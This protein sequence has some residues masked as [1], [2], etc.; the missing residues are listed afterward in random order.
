MGNSLFYSTEFF[1]KNNPDGTKM[2]KN[3]KERT[4]MYYFRI[5]LKFRQQFSNISDFQ[6]KKSPAFLRN[7]FY[8][9]EFEVKKQST[10]DVTKV[11]S[12][13]WMKSHL[14]LWKNNI[15]QYT[16]NAANNY[17][18]KAI[19]ANF[20]GYR[21]NLWVAIIFYNMSNNYFLSLA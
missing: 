16:Y 1:G 10:K 5:I 6:V 20:R 8:Q 13:F 9:F 3:R 7:S 18:F 17:R 4:K 12:N 19:S 11:I 2:K 15:H 21:N 14:P